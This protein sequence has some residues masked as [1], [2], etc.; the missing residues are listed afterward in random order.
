MAPKRVPP[1]P[2]NQVLQEIISEIRQERQRRGSLPLWHNY[3][4][5]RDWY[6]WWT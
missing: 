3:H 2:R 1:K 5:W 6:N 4:N